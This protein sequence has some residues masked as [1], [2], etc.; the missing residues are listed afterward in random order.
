MKYYR[1]LFLAAALTGL[2]SCAVD[3][4]KEFEVEK[5]QNLTQYEYL[6][7]YDVLKNYVDR[8]ASPDFKL[9][10]AL[11]ASD[12]T[13]KAQVYSLAV[14]NFDEVTAGNAM[15]Y[16]SVVGND[17]SM[18]FV[19]V[20]NLVNTAEAAG[21]TVY[22]HT[23]A[24]HSQ[25]N[26]KYLNSLIA[27]KEIKVEAGA[28]DLIEDGRIEW[29]AYTSY[30]HY[31][32]GYTPT[33]ENGILKSSGT[34]EWYQYFVITDV[35]TDPSKIY[36]IT[37]K[38]KGSS[39]GQLTVQMGNWG[40]Q[41][42]TANMSFTDQWAEQSV[43]ISGLTSSKSFVVFQ[44]TFN[45]EIELEW[46]KVT[47]EEA[48]T[49]TIPV[50]LLEKD[51]NDGE[52]PFGGWG[53]QSSRRVEDGV[54][55]ISNPTAGQNWEAQMAWDTQSPFNANVKY[56]LR[57]KIKGSA[58][59]NFAAGFQ[60][61]DGYKSAGEF[62]NVSFGTEWKEVDVT[63]VCSAE[64][65]TRLIFSFGA[66]A[67]DIYIDD[68]QFYYEKSA[69]AIPLTPEEKKDTLTWAMDNWIKGMMEATAGK[70][71]TWDVVNEAISGTDGDG[72]GKYDLWS[73]ENGDAKNNF[74]WQDY[75]GDEEYVRLVVAKA[76]QYYKEFGGT[77]PLKLFINDYNLESDWDQNKKLKSLIK[78]VEI[79]ESDG[80]TK[81]DGLATQM[82]VSCYA[83][84]QTQA[85]KKAAVV[86]MFKL[87]AATGKLVKVSE[88]DMGYVDANGNTVPTTSMTEAQHQAMAEYYE[89][90]VSE[91][92]KNVPAAQRYGITQWC[93]TDASGELGT[94]WRG[95]EPVGLWDQSYNRK[96]TYAGFA[97]GLKAE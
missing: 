70:V 59:G 79:W 73:A 29:S 13:A 68:F 18:N 77:E 22:G 30:P 42:P 19:N 94:G 4:L 97:E 53:L 49:V 28:T 83:N 12:F 32:M 71:S 16:G 23:L 62:P 1:I 20:K 85:S 31:V 52:S 5:P 76:R 96:H 43:K 44:T 41:L 56:G 25:Q 50:T 84:P 21:M 61:T 46:L 8:T 47:H 6:N 3:P 89:F 87:M 91:Y 67:G 37:A 74:Y 82:H 2:S 69:N 33:I 14:S 66:F 38:I 24:W 39:E 90:I 60:I 72:D 64:G 36:T 81:I 65:A 15:K 55:I 48:K 26:N 88:L 93:L 27:D 86:E 10:A 57:Y 63:C 7:E 34:G 54:L 17:G 35:P 40:E 9:G 75:L 45:G 80:V 51:F 92:F 95:G 78:W 11:A 58:A